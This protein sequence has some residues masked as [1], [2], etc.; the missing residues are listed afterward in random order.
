M[1]EIHILSNRKNETIKIDTT[2]IKKFEAPVPANTEVGRII[3]KK[4]EEVIDEIQ[5]KTKEQVAKK[6]IISYFF[7]IMQLLKFAI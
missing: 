6:G 5:I 4:G 3:V 2:V 7:E 1:W